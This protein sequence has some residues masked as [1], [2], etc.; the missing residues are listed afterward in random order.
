MRSCLWSMCFP[1]SRVRIPHRQCPSMLFG[2]A[3]G[4]VPVS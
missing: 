4:G 3:R 2:C 1:E